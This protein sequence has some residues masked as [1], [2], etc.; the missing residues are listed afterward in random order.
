MSSVLVLR[1]T[2]GPSAGR[3]LRVDAP[4]VLG[5][6]NADVIIDDQ[7][8][9]RRHAVIRAGVDW[10]E[11]EDLDSLNGTW[12]N[13]RRVQSARLRLGDVVTIGR[14]V[15][16]VEAARG[17]TPPA[18]GPDEPF[19]PPAEPT[20]APAAASPPPTGEPAEAPLA[21]G[22]CPECSAAV[23]SSARFCAYCGVSLTRAS[24][25]VVKEADDGA[26][27][28]A[29]EAVADELRPVTALFADVVGSTALGERLAPEEVKA[30]IGEC[31]TRMARAIEQYGG[32]V[33]AFMGD[34]IAAFFGLPAA[35]EDDPERAAGAALRILEVVAEYARDI[36]VAWGVTDFNVRVGVNS[37]Q[38]AV[39]IVGGADR[40]R[41]ALGDTT[42]VAARLQTVA[43]PG[44]IVVGEATARRLARRF[45]L[46]S[47]GEVTVKGRGQA[48]AAWRLIGLRTTATTDVAVPLVGRAP[49]VAH[50][51]AAVTELVS[52]RGQVLLVVGDTGMGKSRLLAELRTI[53]ADVAWLEG[54][55]R[56]FDGEVLYGPLVEV[57]RR[58]LG[59]EPG[60]SE[61]SVR[62]KLRAR[63]ASLAHLDVDETLPWLGRLLGVRVDGA[64]GAAD[65]SREDVAVR[66][67]RAYCAWVE[68]VAA[69]Q[70]VLLALDDLH[71][72]D[73]ETRGLAEELLEVTDR[74]PLCVAVCLRT[75][76]PSEGLRFRLHAL[77]HYA[78]R[79]IEIPLGPLSE[80]AASDLLAM[81]VPEDLDEA[82]RAEIV[83]RAEGNP[84]YVEEL[85]RSLIEGGGLERRRQTWAL[86]A[87]PSALL[88]PA[89]ESLLLARIDQLDE[90][91]RRLAQVAAVVGR[92]FPVRVLER[93]AGGDAFER[94]LSVLLRAQ[95]VR[96]VRRYPEL[97][98]AFKHGLLREAAFSTLT[99]PRREELYAR[100]AA[101]FDDLYA[102]SRDE[103]LELL[104]H[105]YARSDNLE[106]ALE[107]LE[108]AGA[109]AASLDANTQA[110][111]LWDRA[112]KVAERLGDA[113]AE[114]RISDRLA[115]AN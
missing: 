22:L 82:A 29:R 78:H 32:T 52:G 106:K 85:L 115:H 17:T 27:R 76:V 72:A 90:G 7:E 86:T 65:R 44:T 111:Q 95:C 77:E 62:T 39:G 36:A 50:L 55:C 81:I 15:V 40:R 13:G 2:D 83:S 35:H 73:P 20:S 51:R 14:T 79:A 66:V 54:H 23:P 108:R 18:A 70:P 24:T 84:L 93:L 114:R 102:G 113:N 26:G 19:G 53:A 5:R 60:E 43:G 8:I 63:L 80:A 30:L 47:L 99:R 34:G 110:V 109:R 103:H 12:V 88:P 105:Y 11:I 25:P 3:A 59:V 98:Y 1:I 91:A 16:A 38:A 75:D 4:I 56:S 45:A 61:V 58:W 57:L 41:V 37:G 92:T 33:D 48:V 46:E 97:V 71:W 94:D 89:L 69:A 87:A 107:Y 67:H 9:S 74:A 31:V 21:E 28:T 6:G 68:A 10:L 101:V 100:V 112:K 42:N 96:E 64:A 104:A 49:E